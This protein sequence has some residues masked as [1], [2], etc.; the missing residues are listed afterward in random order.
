MKPLSEDRAARDEFISSVSHD[1][2]TPLAAIKASVGVLLANEPGDLS[3]PLHRMLVNIDFAADELADMVANLLE[4][5]RIQGGLAVTRSQLHDLRGLVRRVA[6]VFEPVAKRQNQV[7]QVRMPGTPIMGY[8][9]IVGVQRAL[10]NLL[11][12]AHKFAGAGTIIR[13]SLHRQRGKVVFAVADDGPGIALADRERIFQRTY[14]SRVSLAPG[15]T[16][17]GLGLPVARAVAEVHGGQIWVE[18]KPGEGATFRVSLP[19]TLAAP[20]IAS[21]SPQ[22]TG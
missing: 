3:E 16:G 19:L 7:L 12:N 5:V 9:D 22:N 8:C 20:S 14:Q 17:A 18:G 2:R 4:L 13:L 15:K 6:E 11:S 10:L 21:T 1:L